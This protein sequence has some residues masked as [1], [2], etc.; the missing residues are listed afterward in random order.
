MTQECKKLHLSSAVLEVRGAMNIPVGATRYDRNLSNH[1]TE[2][3]FRLIRPITFPHL[4][5]CRVFFKLNRATFFQHAQN[6]SLSG[7]TNSFWP[8]SW[9]CGSK[10]LYGHSVY[11]WNAP[12]IT[13]RSVVLWQMS[14][15]ANLRASASNCGWWRHSDWLRQPLSGL[16]ALCQVLQPPPESG[17]TTWPRR[18]QCPPI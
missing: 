8:L 12:S 7:L 4:N 13:V 10:Q 5:L 16:G 18:T 6:L 1:E 15:G 3:Q 11:L 9:M 17:A 14:V 2:T